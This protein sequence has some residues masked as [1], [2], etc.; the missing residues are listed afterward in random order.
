[1]GA[2]AARRGGSG[3]IALIAGTL[4]LIAFVAV[5]WRRGDR[6]MI[7]VSLFTSRSFVGLTVLTLLLYGA[8]GGLFLL[9][10]Y[11]LIR[12]SGYSAFAAGAA[13][14]PLPLVIGVASRAM[15]RVAATIG[16]RLPLTIG[17]VIVA[18]G[19]VLAT[20]IGGTGSYWT[21]VFP[22]LL[23]IAAGMAGAVAP[24]TTAV[25]GAVDA[26][27]TGTASGFNSAIARTGG[28]IA[29]ALLGAALGAQGG[30][31]IAAFHAAAWVAAAAAAAAGVAA[32]TLV[33]PQKAGS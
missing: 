23:V 2:D 16:P 31:L 29:T 24:L 7:P 19:F 8:L 20:R 4:L 33:A 30:A 11:V 6:A 26:K 25:L 14:L 9:L 28:M 10:P 3:I 18:A 5:E 15:G 21:Q 22:A 17:P 32:L 1:M 13:L 12:A 27:H